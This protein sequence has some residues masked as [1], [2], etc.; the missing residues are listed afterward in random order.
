MW[1]VALVEA[2]ANTDIATKS[3]FHTP[4]TKNNRKIK[5]TIRARGEKR[6]KY[7]SPE[8]KYI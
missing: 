2:I 8:Y 4:M 5:I 6:D 1:D 7:G 3:L